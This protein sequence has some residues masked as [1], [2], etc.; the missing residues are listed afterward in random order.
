MALTDLRVAKE[1]TDPTPETDVVFDRT[2][3]RYAR[4]DLNGTVYVRR[5]GDGA[6]ICRLHG[7]GPGESLP[8]FSPDGDV[9]AVLYPGRA[10]VQFWRLPGFETP[11]R[12]KTWARARGMEP[13]M[14]FE[15]AWHEGFCFSPDGRQVA[16]QHPD[17]SI[18]IFDLATTKRV[19]HLASVGRD[20]PL[21]FNPRGGQL[22]LASRTLPRSGTCP[23]AK[24][25][26]SFPAVILTSGIP[27]EKCWP[28]VSRCLRA[29]PYPF[30]MWTRIRGSASWRG[31]KGSWAAASLAPST[32]LAPCLPPRAGAES[33]GCGTRW[34]AGNF[35]A[36]TRTGAHP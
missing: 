7:P 25:F 3:E 11:E 13:A 1:W 19:Q 36:H 33:C 9:L 35:S 26:G 18:G 17:H 5:A 29:T 21:A 22:V 15:Q 27:T 8:R 2:L 31:R 14:F 23:P 24:S 34:R 6:E 30:G 12:S 28:L 20:S 16:V 10:T 32:T 4:P